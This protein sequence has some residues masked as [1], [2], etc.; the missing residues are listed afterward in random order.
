LRSEEARERF[1]GGVKGD[2]HG[3]ILARPVQPR[4]S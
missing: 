3:V 4:L 1:I 2:P